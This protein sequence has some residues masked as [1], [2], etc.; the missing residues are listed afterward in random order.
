MQVHLQLML[1]RGAP[2]LQLFLT[3]N[4]LECRLGPFQIRLL[5]LT[6]LA[7][8][9]SANVGLTWKNWTS[10]TKKTIRSIPDQSFIPDE[11]VG[12]LES[13]R[14][15]HLCAPAGLGKLTL[16]SRLVDRHQDTGTRLR[17]STIH[18]VK[19]ETHEATVLVSSLQ[20][21]PHQSNWKDWLADP[22][23]EAARFAYV[24]SSRSSHL[25]IWAV[26]KLKVE[27]SKTLS[28]LGFEIL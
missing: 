6:Y 10:L 16:Q 4:R 5:H 2:Q 17:F 23:S 11:L 13:L 19:G 25:L 24:A 12:K 26:K 9:G 22:A 7:T 21:G 3:E 8:C 18:Q 27:E 15:A 1:V 14:E 28:G 20:P